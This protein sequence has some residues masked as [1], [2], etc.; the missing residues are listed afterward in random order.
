M[1]NERLSV[2]MIS[3]G[4]AKNLVDSEVMLGLLHKQGYRLTV[5]PSQADIIV[6]NTCTF[7]EAATSESIECILE[8]AR[9][10]QEG[11]CRALILA[12]CMGTRYGQQLLDGLPEV[13]AV[14]GSG[15]VPRIAEVAKRTLSG[16]RFVLVE[17]PTFIY[18]D[19]TPRITATAPHLAFVKIAEGCNHRCS[20]CVI[21]QVRGAYRSRPLRSVVK[22]TERLVAAGAKEIVLVAQDTTLYGS[23]LY[24]K[25]CLSELLNRLADIEGVHWL[26]L[27]Y[28]YPESLT[29]EVLLTIASRRNICKYVDL[30]LQHV[31]HSLL[32]AMR[33]RGDYSS[34]G[35]LVDKI[36][37]LI[38]GVALRTSFIVGF[39]GETEEQFAELCAFLQ[40][41]RFD[42]VGVFCYSAE[43]GTPAASMPGQV[44][45]EVQQERRHMAM[46][47]QRKI[48]RENNERLLAQVTE[49]LIDSPGVA[50]TPRQA[51]DVD[52]VALVR[53]VCPRPG[54]IADARIV[55]ARDYDLEVE[56]V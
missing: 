9:Y 40:E 26:R 7:I 4:C 52:G 24:G 45:K 37:A 22:E 12:G 47:I 54:A 48:S 5:D 13:N 25:P 29:D 32:R 14:I 36:R 31:N 53:G 33:R 39:P 23:D 16:E 8:M 27:L 15:E 50:R 11:R 19:T 49:V 46:E 34:I 21:P 6:I 30:P 41:K 18:S 28:T 20:Y 43:E 51:P 44:S 2:G 56:V 10:K 42:H 35:Q 3:L 17:E 55:G 1:V 38:P